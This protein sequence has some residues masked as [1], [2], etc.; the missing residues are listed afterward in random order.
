ML[1][2]RGFPGG[3]KN[4]STNAGDIREESLIP[5]SG[6]S[7]AGRH[8]NPLQYSCLETLMDR[9]ACRVTVHSIVKSRTQL[10]QLNTHTHT[11]ATPKEGDQRKSETVQQKPE[12]KLL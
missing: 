4:L 1:Q 6:R 2:E 9:G 11:H 12:T 8:G 5:G 7:S 10:K 3:A